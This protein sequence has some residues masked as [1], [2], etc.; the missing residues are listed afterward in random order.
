MNIDPTKYIFNCT[1]EDFVEV[2]KSYFPILANEQ[3]VDAKEE[4]GP[5]FKGRV[6]YGMKG[7]AEALGCSRKSVYNWLEWLAPALRR[8]GPRKIM[9]DVDYAL[10]LYERHKAKLEKDDE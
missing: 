6:A 7:I 1:I 2:M 8:S 5:T 10:K 9:M 3:P 4:D